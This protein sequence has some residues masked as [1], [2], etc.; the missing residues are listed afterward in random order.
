MNREESLPLHVAASHSNSE[1]LELIYDHLRLQGEAGIDLLNTGEEPKIFDFHAKDY[2]NLTPLDCIGST[3]N[4]DP[5][6]TM[7]S[8]GMTRS[9]NH[10]NP[11][12]KPNPGPRDESRLKD[13]PAMCYKFLRA[14]GALRGC[15]L[16]GIISG[17]DTANHAQPC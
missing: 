2:Y 5:R 4:F 7:S 16:G 1:A 3:L 13:R 8:Y 14:Y 17:K 12:D 10:W 9:E 11:L 15:E 6:S